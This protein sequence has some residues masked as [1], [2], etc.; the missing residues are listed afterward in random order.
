MIIPML[1]LLGCTAA[2]LLLAVA[3]HAALLV[4][5]VALVAALPAGHRDTGDRSE[6]A[7]PGDCP[8]RRLESRGEPGEPTRQPSRVLRKRSRIRHE[9]SVEL[10][11]RE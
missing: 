11:V 10:E 4:A 7:H 8:L 3:S 5:I 6:N 2:D 1:L 9:A